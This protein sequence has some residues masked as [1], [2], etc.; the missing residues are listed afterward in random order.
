[1][2]EPQ[3][4]QEWYQFLANLSYKPKEERAQRLQSSQWGDKYQISSEF[5]DDEFVSVVGSDVLYNV[6]RGSV[7]RQDAATDVQLALNQLES[8][9]RYKASYAKSQAATQVHGTNKTV[10]EVGHSLG[11]TLAET[12]AKQNHT[13]SVAFNMGTTPLKDYKGTD[14]QQHQ[15][16][17]I[18]G[19][20][21]SSFDNSTGVSVMKPKEA[22]PK[23]SLLGR[24]RALPFGT[25]GGRRLKRRFTWDHLYETLDRHFLSKFR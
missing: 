2:T 21:V 3:D 20:L 22:E 8:T 23:K 6:H 5:N 19:D 1:M 9:D 24:T 16:Y 12:I 18:K 4:S 7:N 17:R 25:P 13:K 11:G 15:H 14:R 10:I